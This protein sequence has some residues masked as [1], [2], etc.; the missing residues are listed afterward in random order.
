MHTSSMMSCAL[1][2]PA[3]QVQKYTQPELSKT[4]AT[5]EISSADS[6]SES[7]TNN[8]E[9]THRHSEAR[10]NGLGAFDVEEEEIPLSVPTEFLRI[11]HRPQRSPHSHVILAAALLDV[12]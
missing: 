6:C 1:S 5:R 9:V 7:H 11:L 12:I 4:S 2:H 8:H 3:P 10:R